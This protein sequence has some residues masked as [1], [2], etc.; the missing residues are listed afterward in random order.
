MDPGPSERR[1]EISMMTA[2]HCDGPYRYHDDHNKWPV[3]TVTRGWP[4][5][6]SN[7]HVS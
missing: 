6:I 3:C 1:D 5:W 2:Q 7:G 4:R